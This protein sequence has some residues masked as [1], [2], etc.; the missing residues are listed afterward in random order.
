MKRLVF[1]SLVAAGLAALPG[2]ASAQA[3]CTLP[4]EN[5]INWPASGTPVWSLCWVRA[6]KSSGGYAS[7]LEIRNVYYNG[8]LALKRGHVPILNAVYEGGNCGGASHCYRDIVKTEQGY[9]TDN[10]CPA[11]FTGTNCGYAEPTCPPVMQC[12][13][14]NGV[15]VCTMGQPPP[16]N[17]CGQLCFV[18]VSAQKLPDRLILSTQLRAGW[19]RYDEEWTFLADGT[20]QPSWGFSAVQDACTNFTHRH[21]AYWRLDFDIDGADRD[22]VFEG[23]RPIGKGKIRTEAMRLTTQPGIYWEI[24]DRITD[25]GYRLVPGAE[26]E[27]V[28]P[29]DSFAVGDFWVLKY[30]PEELDDKGQPGPACAIKIT[31]FLN[32]ETLNDDLVVWYRTG[33]RHLGHD[34]DHCH[35]VGPTLV[36]LGDW[37]PG[38]P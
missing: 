26:T 28:T 12:D 29:A 14:L 20:I 13:T 22:E 15:D 31:P 17:E 9:L 6:T 10:I 8:H 18:G 36:P 23:P 5:L 1:A 33:I 24:T 2:L 3:I 21:N 16:P 19:Y 37:S 38:A 4:N 25:R 30:K 27:D 7:G 34:L 35:V 32:G 11:P